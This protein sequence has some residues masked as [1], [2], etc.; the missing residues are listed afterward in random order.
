MR[1]ASR[2]DQSHKAAAPPTLPPGDDAVRATLEERL[3]SEGLKPLYRELARI[4]RLRSSD[5]FFRSDQAVCEQTSRTMLE[6][7]R[8][9]GDLEL[10]ARALSSLGDAEYMSGRFVSAKQY[11]NQCIEIAESKGFGRMLGPNQMMLGYIAHFENDFDARRRHYETAAD[12][13]EKAH[14]LRSLLYKYL[15]TDLA[16]REVTL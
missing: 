14:D 8:L 3:E 15:V 11:F 12:L 2:A 13:S 6:Y 1:S 10:E 7:A 9:A 16:A 5:S 4:Y